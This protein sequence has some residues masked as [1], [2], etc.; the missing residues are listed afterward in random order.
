[1]P[2]QNQSLQEL[3]YDP[4]TMNLFQ[5]L[6]Q[7][8]PRDPEIAL[9]ILMAVAQ[10]PI[11]TNPITPFEAQPYTSPSP[12][13]AQLT[14]LP[15]DLGSSPSVSSTNAYP[16]PSPGPALTPAIPSSPSPASQNMAGIDPL[17]Q[18]YFPQEQWQNAQRVMMGES[19]GRADAV[20]DKLPIRGVLAPSY[21]KFQIRALPGR[22]APQQLLDPDFNVKYAAEMWKQQGWKPWSAAKK[23][24]IK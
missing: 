17:I 11:Q 7:K 14:E 19:G 6:L 2:P 12:A 5:L 22:P 20:G 1:M 8:Y 4:Q 13:S 10:Q 9:K 16:Q 3:G 18:K 24:G 23:L 21:G 15:P